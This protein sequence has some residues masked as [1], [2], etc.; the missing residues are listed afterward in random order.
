MACINDRRAFKEEKNSRDVV[1]G[2]FEGNHTVE[3]YSRMKN[4]YINDPFGL[5]HDKIRCSIARSGNVDVLKSILKDFNEHPII[6]REQYQSCLPDYYE[7][8]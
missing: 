4:A 7:R 3:A 2:L 8:R 1:Y 6:D 5:C